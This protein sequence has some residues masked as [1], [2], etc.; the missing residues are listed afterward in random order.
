[1]LQQ[2]VLKCIQRFLKAGGST[3]EQGAVIG[4]SAPTD[5]VRSTVSIPSGP[6]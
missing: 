2:G 4:R 6:Q 1:M 5:V 3:A